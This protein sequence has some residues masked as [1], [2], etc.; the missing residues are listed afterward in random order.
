MKRVYLGGQK[1]YA[2]CAIDPV[3]KEAVVHIASSPSS[4]SAKAALEKAVARFGKDIKIVNDNGSENMKDAGSCLAS[5]NITQYWTRPYSPKEKPFAE[6]FIGTLQRECLD[7]NYTP[8][9]VTELSE[10]VDAWL[11]KYHFYRPHQSLGFLT[12]AEFSPILGV[13]IPKVVGVL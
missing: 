1:H 6:R 2:F 3:D 7:Y 9:N 11:D 5:L 10:V 4:R 13:S 12:P 8:L